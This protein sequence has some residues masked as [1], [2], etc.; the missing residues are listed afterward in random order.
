MSAGSREP[1]EDG[2]SSPRQIREKVIPP[3]PGAPD[4]VARSQAFDAA[5]NLYVATILYVA[6]ARF[7]PIAGSILVSRPPP[8]GRRARHSQARSCSRSVVNFTASQA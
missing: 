2:R 1:I 7:L 8:S 4:R 6:S 5:T 3:F